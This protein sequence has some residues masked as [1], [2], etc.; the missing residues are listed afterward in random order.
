MTIGERVAA[1][2]PDE[3]RNEHRLK[4]AVNH[5]ATEIAHEYL[6]EIAPY[7]G[8]IELDRLFHSLPGHILTRAE[9]DSLV[10]EHAL[11]T[12][13]AKDGFQALY[14]V[15]LLGYVQHDRVRGEWRQ[16][17]LRPG[18]ATLDT[19]GTLPRATH[20][21]LHPVLSDVIG[22]VNPGFLQRIDRVNIVGYDRPWNEPGQTE[23]TASARPLCVL[24]ADV[25][26]FGSLMRSGTDGPVRKALEDAVLRWAPTD[27][28]V[29][30]GAGDAALIVDDDPVAL[31][32]TAR[33]LMDDVY[34][35]PGQ[36]RLRIALHYGEVQTRQRD[37]DLR[38]VVVGGDAILCA[39]RVEPLVEPGQIWATE[40]FRQQFLQRPSLWRTIPVPAP[41]DREMFNARKA[42]SQEPDLWVRLY[43]LES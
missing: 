1:L 27:S 28:V 11:A 38:T 30:T 5:A 41:D 35:A 26:A 18:E 42:G 33:H 12:G 10:E 3:R 17:F 32:Q 8:D 25:H 20:Y 4:E 24:K 13:D 15:G 43:R 37:S 29:E 22:R 16:R 9:L 19:N 23:R 6:A 14:R 39:A 21:L 40:E 7:I 36:P 31:A 2:R 34:Q